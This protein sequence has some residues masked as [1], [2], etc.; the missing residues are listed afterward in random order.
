MRVIGLRFLAS[1][2]ALRL[3][4]NAFFE[5]TPAS[6]FPDESAFVASELERLTL[7]AF[8]TA[9]ISYPFDP[10]GRRFLR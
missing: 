6:V 10:T 9:P 3:A 1:S 5:V 4:F 2:S 7:V 8:A